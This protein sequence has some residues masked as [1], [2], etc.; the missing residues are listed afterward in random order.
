MMKGAY[1]SGIKLK[2]NAHCNTKAA[3]IKK[4]PSSGSF[5]DKYFQTFSGMNFIFPL[6]H[7]AH[8]ACCGFLQPFLYVDLTVSQELGW[9][10][11]WSWLE[12]LP[13]LF[14]SSEYSK[15][16]RTSQP[17]KCRQSAQGW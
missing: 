8:K 17:G 6:S 12:C 13:C 9:I 14:C 7:F 3:S 5:T 11:C 2:S 10:G 4:A 1:C 16:P 15:R